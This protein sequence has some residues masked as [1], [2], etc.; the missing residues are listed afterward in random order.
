MEMEFSVIN[1][2]QTYST[3]PAIQR[4]N[5]FCPSAL[6][7]AA[8]VADARLVEGSFQPGCAF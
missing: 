6:G 2:L 4:T 5:L 7:K 1:S 8:S 3:V